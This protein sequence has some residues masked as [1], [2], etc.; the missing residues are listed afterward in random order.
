MESTELLD[1]LLAARVRELAKELRLETSRRQGLDAAGQKAYA[2]AHPLI[3][4]KAEAVAELMTWRINSR[5]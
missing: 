2:E 5:S 4:F 3:E 1:L